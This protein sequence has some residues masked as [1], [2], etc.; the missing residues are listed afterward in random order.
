MQKTRK[1]QKVFCEQCKFCWR[2]KYLNHWDSGLDHCN[3]GDKINMEEE[4]WICRAPEKTKI[5]IYENYFHRY[6]EKIYSEC[7][8]INASNDCKFFV[9]REKYKKKSWFSRIL[10]K[11]K[12]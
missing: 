4:D 10:S 1:D 12:K 11:F 2:R 8:D 3:F 5:K 6:E 9:L 7:R